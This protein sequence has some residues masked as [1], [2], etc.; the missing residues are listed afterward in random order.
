MIRSSRIKAVIHTI[1]S[2]FLVLLIMLICFLPLVVLLVIP[3][4]WR[5]NK[6]FFWCSHY[7]FYVPLSYAALVPITIRGREHIPQEPAIIAA[8]H[9]SSL[10]IPL[11]G[12]LLGR[13]PH[14]WLAT[15]ELLT[16]PIWRFVLPRIAV[17]VDTATPLTAMRTLIHAIERVN[18]HRRHMVVFPEGARYSDGEIHDFYGGF[19]VLA[20]KTGRAVVPIRIF[21]AEKLYPKGAFW[22]QWHPITL[23]VGVPMMLQD[24]ETDEAFKERIQAWFVAQHE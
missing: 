19:V 12:M 23:V 7:L 21:G 24:D 3:E 14:V 2:R 16:S 4:R 17:L 15:N 18:G 22:V 1:V 20:K 9:Q 6:V 10:D 5:Y 13:F 8:N 11:V